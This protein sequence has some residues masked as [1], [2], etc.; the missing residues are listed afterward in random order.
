MAETE[1]YMA[2]Y[3]QPGRSP[4]DYAVHKQAHPR[5]S[6]SFLPSYATYKPSHSRRFASDQMPSFPRG[7]SVN[8]RKSSFEEVKHIALPT[9]V[10]AFGQSDLVYWHPEGHTK[11]LPFVYNEHNL[12]V[13]KSTPNRRGMSL[14]GLPPHQ[15]KGHGADQRGHGRDVTV[16]GSSRINDGGQA[17]LM[18]SRGPASGS[19][20]RISFPGHI[21]QRLHPNPNVKHFVYGSPVVRYRIKKNHVQLE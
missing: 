1:H 13:D 14:T 4:F 12:G 11:P 2:S 6:D 3:R 8:N 5:R 10:E 18:T 9:P 19:W 20:K 7:Y 15:S 16:L 17:S 21:A